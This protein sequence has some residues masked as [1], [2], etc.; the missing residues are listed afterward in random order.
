MA[1]HLFAL[2][3][4]CAVA[5]PGLQGAPTSPALACSADSQEAAARLAVRHVNEHHKHGYKFKLL[6]PDT[7]N[8]NFQQQADG[9]HIDVT[10]NLLQTNCHVTNPKTEDQCE[11]MM[12]SERPAA[13][14]CTS[15]L[16]VTGGVATVTR[17]TCVTK[18][19]PSNA[20]MPM[21]C[22]DCPS[23]LPL[24]D[25]NGV[26]AAQ[27]A[28]KKYN[29]ES[30]H[31]HYFTLMEISKLTSG[32]IPSVGMM[33]W[34]NFV[35]VETTCPKHSRIVPEACTPRCPDRAHHAYCKVSYS[36][37]TGQ[38]GDLTCELYQ[39]KD[40][41]PLPADQQEPVC[42][43][44]FHH[45]PEMSVCEAQ[46]STREPAVHQICPFPLAVHLPQVPQQA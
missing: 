23:L 3:L 9:C 45:G 33:T 1:A 39:P 7:V 34:I 46:L 37:S 17:H 30:N 42:P 6:D 43:A 36:H 21:I 35:L 44:L 13:A 25:E 20:E 40:S 19:E 29:R 27:E 8:S 28:V 5:A 24:N 38:L 14:T 2:L 12:D 16:T 11:F 41:S 18:P 26:K 10:M 22:P 31:A 32:Y 15:K 4:C